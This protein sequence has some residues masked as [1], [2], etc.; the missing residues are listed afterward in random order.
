MF[1][2]MA[3]S[4]VQSQVIFS[5]DFDGIPG[6][7]AGG[8]GTYTF[9]SGWLLRNVDNRTPNGQ[10]AY[11][12]EA[13][14]RREDF[15]L[16][17]ADSVAFSASYY[18]PA[19]AA[20]D[21]MWT[22]PIS[23]TSANT[24]LKWN[25][26]AYDPS[27]PDG[28]EVRVMSITANP[29]GPTGGTGVI[30]NQ[31][32]NSTVVFSTTA[33]TSSWSARQVPLASYTGQT[34][35]IAF[36]NT[37]NDM[38]LL[39]IDDVIVE[40]INNHDLYVSNVSH[41]EYTAAPADQQTTTQNFELKGTVNSY[42]MM[43]CTNVALGCVVS[44]D[45]TYLTSVQSAVEPS[46]AA[47]ASHNFTIPF[48]PTING[49]YTFKFYPILSETDDVTTN[50]TLSDNTPLLITPEYM[51]RDNGTVVGQLGIGAGNGGYL[52]QTFRFENAV[53]LA[54]ISAY[55]TRG[56]TGT[57]LSGAIFNTDVNGVPT[58][59][60][61]VTDTLLYPDDSARLYT[62]PINGGTLQLPAGE[63]GFFFVEYDMTAAL[64]VTSGYYLANTHYV[65]WP[66]NPYGPAFTPVESFGSSFQRAFMLYPNFDLCYGLAGGSLDSSAQAS[67]N[68]NNGYAEV[69]LEPGFSILW[70][71]STTTA[72]NNSLSI[73]TH[74]FT[75]T[76]GY[77]SFTDSV[78]IT[79]PVPPTASLDII[80]N[81]LCAGDTGTITLDIQGGTMPYTFIWSDGTMNETFEGS[82]GTYSVTVTDA[83]N[84]SATVSDIVMT[85]PAELIGTASSTDETCSN[86]NDG[87]AD[88]SATGGTLPYS[89]QW[90]NG[91]TT[92]SISNL[93]PGDYTGTIIDANGCMVTMNTS[94]IA[95]PV[96]GL[97][98]LS[99]YG[100]SVYPNPV[101]NTLTVKTKKA[102]VTSIKLLD[103]SGRVIGT[104]AQNGQ[105]FTI[106][107]SQLA[108]GMYQL[109]IS[110]SYGTITT[111]VTKQ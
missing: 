9:P 74:V 88:M 16:N 54:S 106:D 8:A 107:M 69:A 76:N 80:N 84:C 34:V 93:P 92:D 23:I 99:D 48:T 65:N 20:D 62:L 11:V 21:W 82:A 86:C 89:Y 1:A 27:Y 72:I 103:A 28:Y 63:Y 81:P 60:L 71:D 79:N 57:N 102:S 87:M 52:G 25:A 26:R 67:C 38:F 14:E 105:L 104:L 58:T 78:E 37:S 36:R 83:S 30:G 6:P 31:V 42:G 110:G 12:N 7:T 18:S 70:D 50:D 101:V 111:S 64:G 46:V 4:A 73:G 91:A 95:V 56:Y 44:V 15:G 41:G 94:V 43:A 85:E 29:G 33:E 17:V 19:G 97:N 32:T 108:K 22:P 100:I 55:V 39:V 49:N 47:G 10:V 51:R 59:L 68:M 66:T 90:S 75:M 2:L 13:W 109:A 96:N 98:E 3:V 40:V 53:D 35:R 45:G 61:A 24:Y 5:E 77:C